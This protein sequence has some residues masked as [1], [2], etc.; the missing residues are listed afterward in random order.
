[1]ERDTHYLIVGLFVLLTLVGGFFF[2]GLFYDKPVL[3]TQRYAIHFGYS[4]DG[5]MRGSEVRYMGL[6]V[7]EVAAIALS[8]YRA[9]AGIMLKCKSRWIATRL[10]IRQRSPVYASR[11]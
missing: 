2:A 7:G 11:V 9:R 5:L 3:N 10:W 1:M 6:K 4:V 8:R